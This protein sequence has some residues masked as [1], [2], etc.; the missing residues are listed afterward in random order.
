MD[1]FPVEISVDQDGRLVLEA[2]TT[3]SLVGSE[4]YPA[5][6][7]NLGPVLMDSRK[8]LGIRKSAI[9]TLRRLFEEAGCDGDGF[10]DIDWYKAGDG[11]LVFSWLGPNSVRWHPSTF[12]DADR[13]KNARFWED[14]FI[15][16]DG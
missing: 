6:G 16:V 15:E 4:L 1:K 13:S 12:H 10:G 8:N 3:H 9:P 14:G 5:G 2:D 7:S 11:R